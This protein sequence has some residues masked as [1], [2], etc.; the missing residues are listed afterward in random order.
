[1]SERPRPR[2]SRSSIQLWRLYEGYEGIKGL[3]DQGIKDLL[4]Q[5]L[6]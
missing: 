1:M 4:G 2:C 3:W 5:K 6:V